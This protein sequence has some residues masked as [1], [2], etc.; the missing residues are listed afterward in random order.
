MLN[1]NISGILSHKYTK[2]K[3][4]AVDDLPLQK[5]LNIQNAAILINTVFHENRNHYY[6]EKVLDCLYK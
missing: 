3:V 4:Y 6:H 5:M 1:S 2:I